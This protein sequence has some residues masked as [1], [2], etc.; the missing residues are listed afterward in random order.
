[1]DVYIINNGLEKKS[2][3]T[4]KGDYG[5]ATEHS[6]DST[7]IALLPTG[8]IYQAGLIEGDIIL[9]YK[10]SNVTYIY[11]GLTDFSDRTKENLS[12][13]ITYIAY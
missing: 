1:M 6:G 3:H 7:I 8:S 12:I 5:L 9:T 11:V 4:E 13:G 2:T 10:V